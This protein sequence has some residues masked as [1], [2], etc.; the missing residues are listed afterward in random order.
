MVPRNLWRGPTLI[1][2][3]IPFT[4]CRS[5]FTV[6]LT[7]TLDFDLILRSYQ[8]HLFSVLEPQLVRVYFDST[9]SVTRELCHL[10]SEHGQASARPPVRDTLLCASRGVA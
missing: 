5:S 7:N 3:H 1:A 10:N 2:V 9:Q 6:P 4:S 8:L